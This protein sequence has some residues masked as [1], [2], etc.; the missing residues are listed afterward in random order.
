M[1]CRLPVASANYIINTKRSELVLLEKEFKIKINILSDTSVLPGQYA[2][3][4][5]PVQQQN[6]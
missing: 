4:V 1:T 6:G 5:E 3:D 2:V